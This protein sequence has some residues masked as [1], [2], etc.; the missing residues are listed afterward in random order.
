MADAAGGDQR[1][2]DDGAA[3]WDGSWQAHRQAQRRAWWT[4]T[5]AQRLAWLEEAIALAHRVGA[6]PRP[7]DE[8]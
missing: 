5:P 7:R 2:H 3:R 1:S 4:A 6:L 8:A